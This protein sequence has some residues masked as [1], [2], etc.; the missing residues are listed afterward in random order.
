[1]DVNTTEQQFTLLHITITQRLVKPNTTVVLTLSPTSATL[2]GL[3]N[4]TEQGPH[5]L[6]CITITWGVVKPNRTESSHAL[7]LHHHPIEKGPYTLSCITNTWQW[8]GLADP[9][10]QHSHILSCITNT[11]GFVKPRPLIVSHRAY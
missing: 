5:T 2:G 7:L 6:S 1:M 9:T 4:P 10:E 11:Q 8:G 3:M